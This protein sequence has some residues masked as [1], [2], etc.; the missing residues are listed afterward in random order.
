MI[1]TLAAETATLQNVYASLP[2]KVHMIFCVIATLLYITQFIRKGSYHYLT[3]M[4]AIDLTIVTQ[5]TT[6]SFV[7]GMLFGAEAALLAATAFISHRFAKKQKALEN[8]GEKSETAQKE[9][10]E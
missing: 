5:F 3:L 6:K 4:I 1:E 9:D 10:E 8:A 2:F 7:I